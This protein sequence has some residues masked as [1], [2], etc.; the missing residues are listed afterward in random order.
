M[1]ISGKLRKESTPKRV[2]AILKIIKLYDGK[3]E[4]KEIYDLVQPTYLENNQEEVNIVINFLLAEKLIAQNIDCKLELRMP[5][6]CLNDIK[7]FKKYISENI[8][9]DMKKQSLFFEVTSEILS[10]DLDFYEFTGFE[11]IGNILDNK[12]VD[13]E[14]IL[15]WRFWAEF[16][17]F[18]KVMGTQFLINPYYRILDRVIYNNKYL[19][20]NYS[21]NEFI[22]ILKIEC[23][24]FKDTIKDNSIGLS[25][26]VSLRTLDSIGKIRLIRVKD[27][28]QV[29]RLYYSAIDKT[30]VTDIEIVRGN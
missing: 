12:D 14:F 25:L 18:G 30:E 22:N 20:K 5:K 8:F 11:D 15:A 16:L 24:E 9:K 10:K 29:W 28:T 6:E 21:I 17:G 13:K 27:S 4:K 1:L 2:F 23:P 3:F 19:N 26:S 7:I